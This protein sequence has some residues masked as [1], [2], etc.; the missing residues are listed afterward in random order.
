MPSC[1][2]SLAAGPVP[3][4]GVLE[5]LLAGLLADV[6]PPDV[7]PPEVVPPDVVP[8]VVVPP[9]V[10]P[11]D[12]VPPDVVPFVEPL[13][14]DEAPLAPLVVDPAEDPEPP[15]PHAASVAARAKARGT[16]RRRIPGWVWICS[17]CER[18]AAEGES[19]GAR[20]VGNRS[21]KVAPGWQVDG[22][23]S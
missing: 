19:S 18:L 5:G 12:V 1:A 7:D 4:V 8:P 6:E 21:D 9:E 20:G 16:V 3:A 11:P 17:R 22:D 13:A 23:A 2:A 14:G 15:P 10:V